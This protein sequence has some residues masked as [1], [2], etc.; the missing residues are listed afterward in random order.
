MAKRPLRIPPRYEFKYLLPVEMLPGIRAAIAPTCRM[1]PASAS[2]D[3]HRYA[4]SS[5]YLDS[6]TYS[7]HRAKKDR[8]QTRLKLRVRTYP[9]D[10]DAP[11]LLEVKRRVGD[12]IVKGRYRCK[13]PD[14]HADIGSAACLRERAGRDFF[15]LMVRSGAAPTMLVRYEREAYESVVDHYARVTFD[16]NLAFTPTPDWVLDVPPALRRVAD[17]PVSGRTSASFVVLELKFA[18]RFPTWMAALTRRFDLWRRGFS[19]YCTAVEQ[20]LILDKQ[21]HPGARVATTRTS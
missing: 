10:A 15:A 12:V 4:I 21:F 17:D 1:D 14:W 20:H 9:D 11:V 6:P 18:E 8:A 5:L 16:F 7:F 13:G 19:K 3:N 2:H